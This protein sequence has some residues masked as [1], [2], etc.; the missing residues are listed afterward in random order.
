MTTKLAAAWGPTIKQ[1][2]VAVDRVNADIDQH[3]VI[4]WV[5][6]TN[7]GRVH[8]VNKAIADAEKMLDRSRDHLLKAFQTRLSAEDYNDFGD[9]VI[10]DLK[11]HR[12]GLMYFRVRADGRWDDEQQS[13]VV[14]GG[15]DKYIHGF[16][17]LP[18]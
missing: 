2:G 10:D 1:A 6:F 15:L 5:A 12:K 16:V 3:G 17:P 7:Y 13:H 9:I 4:V 18:K 11:E 8:H 14:S